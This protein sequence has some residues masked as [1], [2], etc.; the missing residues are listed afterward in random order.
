MKI[1]ARV[2]EKINKDSGKSYLSREGYLRPGKTLRPPCGSGCRLGCSKKVTEEQREKLFHH[3]YNLGNVTKQWQF[4]S[5]Q[6]DQFKPKKARRLRMRL[7]DTEPPVRRRERNS[8]I[9]YYLKVDDNE[10]IKVCLTMF[11]STFD[12]TSCTIQTVVRKTNPDGIVVES[13]MRGKLS[14]T[15]VD[16]TS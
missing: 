3:Y 4:L 8:N 15:K 7:K 1:G 6:M 5:E 2:R 10:R 16:G 13:D 9:V 14:S 11:T 12:I